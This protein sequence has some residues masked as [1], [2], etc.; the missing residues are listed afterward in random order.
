MTGFIRKQTVLAHPL[1]VIRLFGW[2]LFVRALTAP[3]Y[4]TF[5]DLIREREGFRKVSAITPTIVC[6]D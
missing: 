6:G 2:R 1:L 3:P 4:T 5:L